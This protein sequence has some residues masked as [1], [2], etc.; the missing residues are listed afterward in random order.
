MNDESLGLMSVRAANRRGWTCE[1]K[2]AMLAKL[3]LRYKPHELDKP[4][5]WQGGWLS[6]AGLRGVKWVKDVP[7]Y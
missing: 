7:D 5:I 2:R 1:Q 6:V 3:A 4:P